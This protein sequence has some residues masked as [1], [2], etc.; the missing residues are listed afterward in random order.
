[1][2]DWTELE[3]VARTTLTAI[4]E[5]LSQRPGDSE[6]LLRRAVAQIFLGIAL[7][8]QDKRAGGH[9]GVGTGGDGLSRH[10]ARDG[11]HG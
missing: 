3:R 8:R 1:M 2:H 9:N 4:D 5:G 6:L 10:A 7:L 11:V